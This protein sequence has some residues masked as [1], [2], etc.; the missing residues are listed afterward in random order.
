MEQGAENRVVEGFGKFG[1]VMVLNQ[2]DVLAFDFEPEAVVEAVQIEQF[3]QVLDCVSDPNIVELDAFTRSP[4]LGLP[5]GIFEAFA[6]TFGNP[7]EYEEV[8]IKALEYGLSD[9]LREAFDNNIRHSFKH[10]TG[11][12]GFFAWWNIQAL[13]FFPQIL[14]TD[15][16]HFR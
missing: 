10:M 14:A 4:A 13:S 3:V 16:K 5:V 12:S 9:A 6:S 2:V 1:L 8:P 15:A 11:L 7:G